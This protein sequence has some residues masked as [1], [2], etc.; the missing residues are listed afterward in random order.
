MTELTLMWLLG[1]RVL[2]VMTQQPL[3]N[4]A[5]KVSRTIFLDI[6]SPFLIID[7]A[8]CALA[9]NVRQAHHAGKT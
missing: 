2:Q 5:T 8:H 1:G 3:V 7:R 4:T 9:K 6:L